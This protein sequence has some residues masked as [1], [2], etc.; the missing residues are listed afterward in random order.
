[1]PLSEELSCR[2]VLP[3]L[4]RRPS[5][6][7][8]AWLMTLA[9]LPHWAH[10]SAPAQPTA[11]PS[12]AA[13]GDRLA[14]PAR[15][16]DLREIPG[17]PWILVSSMASPSGEPGALYVVNKHAPDRFIA[18]FPGDR[19]ASGE[20]AGGKPLAIYAGCPAPTMAAFAPHGVNVRRRANGELE[21]LA[22]NH[23]GRESIEVL[24]LDTRGPTP[25]AH[26]KGCVLLPHD[27]WANGVAS[28]AGDE[29]VISSMFDP[30][31]PYMQQFEQGQPTGY[32]LRWSPRTGWRP[33]S[34]IKFSGANGIEVSP[35]QHWLFVAEW[36]RRRVWK[37]P[38]HASVAPQSIDVD[39]LPDNLRWT[40]HGDLLLAGQVATPK[41]VFDGVQGKAPSPAHFNVVRI[42]PDTLA[43][44]LLVDAGDAQFGLG[45]GAIQV[46]DMLWVGSAISHYIRRYPLVDSDVHSA[47]V[48]GN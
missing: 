21:I 4:A 5:A 20:L 3:S 28:L 47:A 32:A 39:F 27:A 25:R 36:A 24:G 16:E 14:S 23:G 11:S 6:R 1:M 29:L 15:P 31:Q 2:G 38:L 43:K 46:D 37:L 34:S 22:V 45:T 30:H 19:L 35:D 33:A 41:A 12:A 8:F 7:A 13:Q 18:L 26:W 10:A 9:A 42:Q 44:T 48:I 17:T 40:P